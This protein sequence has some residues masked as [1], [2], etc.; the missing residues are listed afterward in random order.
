MRKATAKPL[1]KTALTGRDFRHF[2]KI[3]ES[4]LKGLFALFISLCIF[5]IFGQNMNQ[6][7][8]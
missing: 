1:L 2:K 6:R 8:K 4:L 7:K 5:F 3:F